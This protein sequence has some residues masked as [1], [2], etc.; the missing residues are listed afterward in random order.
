VPWPAGIFEELHHLC[1]YPKKRNK[2]KD[3]KITKIEL[4]REIGREKGG[5]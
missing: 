3:G 2:E 1:V 5:G 4:E